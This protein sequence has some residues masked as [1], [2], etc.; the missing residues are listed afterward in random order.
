MEIA[1]IYAEIGQKDK[2]S[3]LSSQAIQIVQKIENTK[4]ERLAEIALKCAE[5]GEYEQALVLLKPIEDDEKV[6]ALAKIA[7]KYAEAE[8]YH[9]ALEVTRTIKHT[10]YKVNVLAEIGFKYAQ[11]GEK[12]DNRARKILREIIE[13]LE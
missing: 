4:A 5:A 9:K 1:V 3:E 10:S 13:D 12:V 8:E 2:A 6:V 11:A 7:I